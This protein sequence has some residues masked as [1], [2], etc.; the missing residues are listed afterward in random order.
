MTGIRSVR[1]GSAAVVVAATLAL[2]TAACG[3]STQVSSTPSLPAPAAGPANGSAAGTGVT[4]AAGLPQ[5]AAPAGGSA[6][7]EPVPAPAVPAPAAAAAGGAA[8]SP[9]PGSTS[10]ALADAQARLGQLDAG[11]TQVSDDVA[12]ADQAIANG[13]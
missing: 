8:T 7:T 13:G 10:P 6:R 3:R 5:G 1:W 2:L 4:P 11:L 9:S 12:S